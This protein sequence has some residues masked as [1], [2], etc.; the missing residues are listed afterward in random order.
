MALGYFAALGLTAV[1]F[2]GMMAYFIP[3]CNHAMRINSATWFVYVAGPAD[4]ALVL[5]HHHT[6]GSRV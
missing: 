5:L 1:V 4:Y 3:T 2:I 6:H